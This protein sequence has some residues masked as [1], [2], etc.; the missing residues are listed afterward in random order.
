LTKNECLAVLDRSANRLY[1]LN[2]KECLEKNFYLKDGRQLS[3]SECI[4]I[5]DKREMFIIKSARRIL[6]RGKM[7]TEFKMFFAPEFNFYRNCSL[8]L[9]R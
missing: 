6:S 3:S 1:P 5:V 9:P 2:T 4:E 7:K 8:Q